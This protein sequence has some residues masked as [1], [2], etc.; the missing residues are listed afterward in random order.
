MPSQGIMQH[1]KKEFSHLVQVHGITATIEGLIAMAEEIFA[2]PI[3]LIFIYQKDSTNLVFHK[4]V[5]A[6]KIDLK[7]MH[8]QELDLHKEHPLIIQDAETLQ[9]EFVNLGLVNIPFYAGCILKSSAGNPIGRVELLDTNPRTVTPKDIHLFELLGKQLSHA[10]ISEI[11]LKLAQSDLLTIFSNAPV[12]M[13]V[14][15]PDDGKI[16]MVNKELQKLAETEETDLIGRYTTEFYSNLHQR[17]QLLE[18]LSKANALM[19][20]ISGRPPRETT[21]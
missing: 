6:S 8:L 18:I 5:D 20:A 13:L 2:P 15:R 1:L 21:A 7:N 4:G 3:L 10:F 9:S 14:A 16:L 11:N 19:P 17:D 12:A